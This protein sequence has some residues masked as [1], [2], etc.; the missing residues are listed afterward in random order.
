M[1]N[2]VDRRIAE[3]LCSRLCHE[4][5]AGVAAINN[6]V[7]LITEIDSSMMDEAMDLIGSSARQSSARLQFYRMAYG[8]AGN[9]ALKSLSEVRELV[10]KVIAGEQRITAGYREFDNIAP[11]APGLGKIMLNLFIYGSDCLPRGGKVT[12]GLEDGRRMIAVAEGEDARVPSRYEAFPTPGIP[13]SEVTAL[14][15]HAYYT[16]ALANSIGGGLE[17]DVGQ[18]VI[19]LAVSAMPQGQ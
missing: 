8:L 2:V 18:D 9:D 11:L 13:S 14:N 6:G 7:E 3:L 4:L 17:L 15:V 12:L 16:T 5:V 19:T 10:E 1:A